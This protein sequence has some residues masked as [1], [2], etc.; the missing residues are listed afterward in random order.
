ML[1]DMPV[2]DRGASAGVFAKRPFATSAVIKAMNSQNQKTL[3]ASL[4]AAL[5]LYFPVAASFSEHPL[6]AQTSSS[7]PQTASDDSSMSETSQPSLPQ[8]RRRAAKLLCDF[9]GAGN[10]NASNDQCEEKYH[11]ITAS[12]PDTY[13]LNQLIA[14]I[15]DPKASRLDY[16]FDR[17]LDAIQ[18]AVEAAGYVLDRFDLPWDSRKMSPQ[19]HGAKSEQDYRQDPGV[20]LFRK[21]IRKST[22]KSHKLLLLYLVGETPT[23]GIHKAAFLSAL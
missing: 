16:L 22:D 4:L 10:P 21:M 3:L 20:I 9:F 13:Q 5:T 17:N 18:R 8:K 1:S 15:P 14:T 7:P 12:I 23:T 6:P 11:L 2:F 19:V